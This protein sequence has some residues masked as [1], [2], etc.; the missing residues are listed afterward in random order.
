MQ[1]IIKATNIEL[2]DE[3]KSFIK[4]KIGGCE[5]FIHTK[6]PIEARCEVG[7]ISSH[8]KKGSVFRAEVNL[9]LPGK[10]LRA[11][12]IQENIYAAINKVKNELEKEIKKYERK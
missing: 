10:L 3:L 9:R 7:K 2:S 8:H 6:F 11:E 12:A 1:I 5:K 4:E